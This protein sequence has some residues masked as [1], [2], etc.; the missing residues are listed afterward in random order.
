MGS[1][2]LQI[3]PKIIFLFHQVCV[4]VLEVV[5]IFDVGLQAEQKLLRFLA[6]LFHHCQLV[7]C[8]CD[9]LLYVLFVRSKSLD[10]RLHHAL[11][12]AC[13]QVKANGLCI[14]AVAGVF[15]PA[16]AVSHVLVH[17]DCHA[18]FTLFLIK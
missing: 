17:H 9:L 4:L 18:Y 2:C 16:G 15:C 3:V 12:L 14:C 5:E 1:S 8:E 11:K 7:D 10:Y 13:F 6:L